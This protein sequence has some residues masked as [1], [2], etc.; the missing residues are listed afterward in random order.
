M[1]TSSALV[2]AKL[3]TQLASVA[4]SVEAEPSQVTVAAWVIGKK[5]KNRKMEITKKRV[6]LKTNL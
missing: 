1:T 5:E 2:G 3:P 6:R 4:Q